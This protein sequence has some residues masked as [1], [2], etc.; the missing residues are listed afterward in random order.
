[1]V[2]RHLAESRTAARE[3]ITSGRVEVEGV[4]EPKAATMVAAS[5]VVR[6]AGP[7]RQ[8][9]SRGGHKLA[10]ALEVFALDAV[11]RRALD[12]GASTGGFT[13]CLLQAGAA[14]VVAVD[15]GYGQIH[16]RLRNDPRV[17]VVERTNFRDADPAGLGAPFDV[18]VVDLSFI[19]LAKVAGRLA[20]CG[21]PGTDHV[22]LVKPQFEVGKGLVGKGGIVRDP[23]LHRSSLEAV[24]AALAAAGLGV[25]GGVASPITG[26]KGNREFLMWARR[27]QGEE[28]AAV[29]DRMLA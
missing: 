26:A 13:D 17:V 18:V 28:P 29:I 1:M 2:R 23:A 6:F 27:G 3:A 7:S 25:R 11:G 4:V 15:V 19:G 16:W 12:V 10:A 14:S 21:G 22:L 20:A 24:A 8:Y 5:T 9:V